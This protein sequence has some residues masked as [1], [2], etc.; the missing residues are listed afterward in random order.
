MDYFKYRYGLPCL[1][2]VQPAGNHQEKGRVQRGRAKG[3]EEGK[4]RVAA[5]KESGLRPSY[6]PFGYPMMY[7]SEEEEKGRV[8]RG[9]GKER[10]EGKHGLMARGGHGLLKLSLGLTMPYPSTPCGWPPLK[11]PQ[12]KRLRPS[13]YPHGYPMMYASE[14]EE[15][16]RVR[17][18]RGKERK[19]GK[20]WAM[21]RGGHGLLKVSLG[22]TMPYP[23]IPCGRPP[24]KR[25]HG[26]FRGGR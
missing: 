7:A 15:K 13:Y 22:P 11:R 9:R 1:T 12:S 10:E 6:Y 14:E 23:S 25:P 20:A 21:V 19:K 26:R 3:R 4:A 2:H 17:R 16:E 5:C 24:L 8:R 18:G